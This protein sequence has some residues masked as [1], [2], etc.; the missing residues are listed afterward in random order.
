[1]RRTLFLMVLLSTTSIAFSQTNVQ[2]KGQQK[3]ET[4]KKLQNQ[5][6]GIWNYVDEKAAE[7]LELSKEYTDQAKSETITELQEYTDQAK[8]EAISESNAYTDQEK[9]DA[10]NQSKVYTDQAKTDAITESNAYTDQEKADAIDQSKV[11]TNQA[12]TEAITES[13]AYTDQEKADA[14]NQSKVYTNQAKTEAITESNAY[15]DQEKADAINQSKVYTDQAKTDAI[16]QSVTNANSYT[17]SK[18]EENIC[19]HFTWNDDGIGIG[20]ETVGSYKL[21][22]EGTIGARE[23]KITT[24]AWADFVFEDDYNLMSLKELESFIQENKH[25]PEIPT[26]AEVKENGIPVGEMNSKLLQ[27]IEE[28]TLYIIKLNE[29]NENIKK[30][31]EKLKLK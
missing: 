22:V 9:A 4:E 7:T 24:D 13:N 12:K 10:I 20:T 6:G 28:L 15:T 11:Y 18:V 30:E 27:K 14:I 25:L 16:S 5:A 2:V 8:Q 19:P 17:D 3:T 26:T 31:I 23:V 21:A 1:M 29:E